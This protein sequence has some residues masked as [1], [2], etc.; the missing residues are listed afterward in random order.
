[1]S[2]LLCSAEMHKDIVEYIRNGFMSSGSFMSITRDGIRY[3]YETTH[4]DLLDKNTSGAELIGIYARGEFYSVSESY[5]N[6]GRNFRQELYA[7]EKLYNNAFDKQLRQYSSHRPIGG[8]I[9]IMLEKRIETFRERD[10][11]RVAL[12]IIFG[13]VG[14]TDKPIDH[15]YYE[16]LF[17][18]Y[19]L[20]GNKELESAV[21]ADIN[22]HAD[23]LNFTMIS[24]DMAYKR[25]AE[26]LQDTEIVEKISLYA[27]I[28]QSDNK[29]YLVAIDFE[30]T[31]LNIDIEREQLLRMIKQDD[32]FTYKGKLIVCFDDIIRIS[33]GEQVFYETE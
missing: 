17:L 11:E 10:M 18:R 24:E 7:F 14:L 5:M 12:D 6:A 16:P 21:M 2:A 4:I 15:S 20:L 22:E 32:A 1:M 27:K 3:I 26:L 30:N 23:E 29:S 9:P 19:L 33:H 8:K 13:N 31:I 28:K 25:A